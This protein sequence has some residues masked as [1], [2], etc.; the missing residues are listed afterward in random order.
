MLAV[1][2]RSTR[3]I[4]VVESTLLRPSRTVPGF[5]THILIVVEGNPGSKSSH[6]KIKSKTN[7]GKTPKMVENSIHTAFVRG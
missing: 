5:S 4:M 3:Q 1:T 2:Q 6:R 7:L